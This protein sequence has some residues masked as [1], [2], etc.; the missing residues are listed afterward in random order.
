MYLG[1][2]HFD[3][4]PAQLAARIYRRSGVRTEDLELPTPSAPTTI[5]STANVPS[6]ATD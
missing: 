1:C 2:Y 5:T 4:E 3:G 6:E